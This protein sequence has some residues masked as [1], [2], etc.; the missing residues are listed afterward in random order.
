LKR[1][2]ELKRKVKLLG[3][4]RIWERASSLLKIRFSSLK[5][6]LAG[7]HTH[8]PLPPLGEPGEEGAQMAYEALKEGVTLCKEGK[9][10]GLL[11]G[12]VAKFLMRKIGFRWEGHTEYLQEQWNIKTVLMVMSAPRFHVGIHTTHIPLKEV[13]YRMDL[14]ILKEQI[15]LFHRFLSALK[16]RTPRIGLCALNPHGGEKGEI[17]NEEESLLRLV[18]TLRDQGIQISDPTSSDTIFLKLRQGEYDGVMALYHDQG[19]IP[20]KLLHFF[21][22]VNVTLGLPI[23]RVSPDHGPAFD[24]AGKVKPDP[25]STEESFR[26][27]FRLHSLYSYD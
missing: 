9:L 19:L 23:V 18:L 2:P 13:P 11:T 5:P 8:L 21:K 1:N 15:L 10:F 20:F 27:A 6:S 4:P 22:G 25:R 24:I 26:L 16:K 3:D 17:G 14:S 12:P 7:S